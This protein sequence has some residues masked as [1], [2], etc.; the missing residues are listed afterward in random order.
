MQKFRSKFESQVFKKLPKSAVYEP[1]KW[2]YTI[3]AS[4]HTYTPDIYLPEINTYVELKGKLDIATRK[5]M[6]LVRDQNP[7]KKIVFVFQNANNPITKGSRTTYKDWA[8]KN[9][10]VVWTITELLRMN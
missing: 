1:E 9:G 2:K 10:F 6:I 4:N 8:E 3:P 5:K 7:E